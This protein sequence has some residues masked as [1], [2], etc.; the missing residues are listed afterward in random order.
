MMLMARGL[1]F[2][3]SHGQPVPLKTNAFDALGTQ[4][5]LHD[6][7][8][9]LG[10]AGHS[11]G[12]A[13]DAGRRDRVR[14]RAPRER[15]SDATCSRSAATKKRRA[16]PASTC[17]WTK[18]LVYVISGGC[19]ALAGMLLMA[20]FSSGSPQTGVGSELQSIAAVV[21]GGT[22][23]M[24]GRGS[25]VATFF[26]ALLD[27]RTQQRDEP[28][29]HRIVHAGH[30]ARCGHPPRR[31]GRRNPQARLRPL[32]PDFD[33]L[34]IAELRKRRS[35]K[36]TMFP[37]DVLPAWVAEMD[38]PLDDGVRAAL[39]DSIDH[40]DCGYANGAGVGA[41][42]AAFAQE[43]FSWTVDP[44]GVFVIPDVLVGI[45]EVLRTLTAARRPD[46]G[47][48]AGVPA[49]LS[50]RRRSRAEDRR[51]AVAARRRR[52]VESR[53]G[54]S[55]AR[56]RRRCDGVLAVL[57]AQPARHGLRSD[58]AGVHRRAGQRTRRARDRRRDSRA[59]H[60][61]RRDVRAVSSDRRLHRLRRGGAG[62][63]VEGVEPSRA[64]S[65]RW[66]WPVRNA[67]AR[68]SA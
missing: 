53:S 64:S 48:L 32:M 39:R 59:A 33:A 51:R 31:D 27:R 57:A 41:A 11:V 22:S 7:L 63:G 1:A 13:R 47:E 4:Y 35:A 52:L 34:S 15:A 44:R 38:F 49:V 58:D 25:V 43:R 5:A 24:G 36:W 14:D 62:V 21:V 18:T 65:A 3:L 40:D 45:S 2:K 56:V 12:R 67:C 28:V 46:R 29:E 17:A 37:P 19:A 61:G 10:H 42:F 55:R 8:A 20:R 50:R 30:R 16:S 54:G 66:R 26:G 6:L 60:D 9:P 68:N 23:L